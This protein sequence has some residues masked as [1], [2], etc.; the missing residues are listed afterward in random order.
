[1]FPSE[2]GVT[3]WFKWS[4]AYIADW[5]MH[6]RLTI[7]AK[8]DNGDYTKLG[9][10]VLA[11]WANKGLFLYGSVYRYDNMVGAGDPDIH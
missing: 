6:F 11:L 3:G 2:Y 7:N 1:M 5:H 9:D 4:G 10:R 8:A